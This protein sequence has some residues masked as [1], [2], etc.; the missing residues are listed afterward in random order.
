[1]A[2]G[3]ITSKWKSQ[4]LSPVIPEMEEGRK[5]VDM[6]PEPRQVAP[7]VSAWLASGS[8][9]ES[10]ALGGETGNPG[11]RGW[12]WMDMKRKTGSL[13]MCRT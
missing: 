3:F 10:E 11:S 13:Q 2:S 7:V 12:V 9:A 4:D 5:N 6:G 1:M 8:S